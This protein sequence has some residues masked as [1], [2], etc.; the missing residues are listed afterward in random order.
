MKL[1]YLI[2]NNNII[3]SCI[4]TN[5]IVQ[6]I[7]FTDGLTTIS[8]YNQ[9][10]FCQ[11]IYGHDIVYSMKNSGYYIIS[12]V[13]CSKYKRSFEPL[14][15]QLEEITETV[16]TNQ[17]LEENPL[18]NFEFEYEEKEKEEKNDEEEKEEK[19]K[20]KEKEKEVKII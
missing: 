8:S 14:I 10:S 1:T 5:S 11:S 3:L 17:M 16:S 15:G 20:E 12:D 9:F 18:L 2:N 13:V 6:A 7:I 4:D 19:E